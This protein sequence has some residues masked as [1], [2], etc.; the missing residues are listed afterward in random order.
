MIHELG[1]G[2]TI[3]NQF[4]SELRDSSIQ[5][6]SLRFR[7]NL[8]RIGEIFAYE[9]SKEMNYVPV[10]VSTPLGMLEMKLIE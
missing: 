10:K 7:L 2:N 6:D 4:L 3:F 8:Q 9:I 1:T 5:K